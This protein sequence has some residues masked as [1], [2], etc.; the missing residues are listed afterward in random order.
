MD[1]SPHAN[2][3][4]VS[5]TLLPQHM[6]VAYIYA[7]RY[8][9]AHPSCGL[10]GW[11]A[12][13]ATAAALQDRLAP[14]CCA[15]LLHSSLKA[16]LQLQQ[17]AASPPLAHE[18]CRLTY[19]WCGRYRRKIPRKVRSTQHVVVAS[20]GRWEWPYML[21]PVDN[22][23]TSQCH[24]VPL[25]ISVCM[26]DPRGLLCMQQLFRWRTVV[27]CAVEFVQLVVS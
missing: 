25:N 4:A 12:A 1:C 11:Q 23:R 18:A 21:A 6:Q 27:V 14:C 7:C 19:L 22:H 15:S 17:Q 24:S 5:V 3:C 8:N 13:A 9:C 16:T 2:T 26:R 20:E 10:T